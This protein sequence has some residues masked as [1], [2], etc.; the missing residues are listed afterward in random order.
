MNKYKN[1]KW[2]KLRKNILKRDGYACRECRRYGY[3][4]DARVVHHV[5]PADNYPYLF[6]NSKNLISLCDSCHNKMHDRMSN[7]ITK[8]GEDWQERLKK[9][10]FMKK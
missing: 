8:C 2:I 5:F 3:M 1:K 7:E 9:E 10:V 6:Y 4:R